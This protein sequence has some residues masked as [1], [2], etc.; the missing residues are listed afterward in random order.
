MK[1]KEDY[2]NY[3]KIFEGTLKRKYK[4]VISVDVDA[5][6]FEEIMEY[7]RDYPTKTLGITLKWNVRVAINENESFGEL[8]SLGMDLF[9]SM[10]RIKGVVPWI[11]LESV[12][13]S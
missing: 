9:Y 6:D 8:S 7:G 11:S 3:Q 2:L 10:F 12:Y 13:E 4:C 5:S 1:Y